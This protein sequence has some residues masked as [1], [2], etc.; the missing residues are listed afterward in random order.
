MKFTYNWLK[1]F[2]DIKLSPEA[3]ADQLIDNMEAFVRG[4]ERNRVA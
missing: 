2:V 1:D 4:E 3:L